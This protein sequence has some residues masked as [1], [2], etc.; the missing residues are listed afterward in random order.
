MVKDIIVN[1]S[2][3]KEGSVVGKYA[4]SVAAALEAHLTGVAFIYDPVVPISGAGYIPAE[5]IEIQRDDNETAAEAA[6]KSFTAATDQAGISAEPLITNASV[7]GAGDHFARMARRFDLAIVGQAE[8]EISS[9]EQIIGETTLFE[10]GRPMIMVPYIQKAPFKTD[11]VMIC[12]DGSRTATRAVADA[13][14]IIRKSGRVEIVIVTNE[15]GKEDE[16]EGAD[17]GQ[18]LARHGLKVDVHRIPGGNIDIAD[19]LLSHAADSS[20]D[21]MVMGGYGHSRLREFVLGGVTRSIFESMTVPVL[22][23]H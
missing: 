12:W 10:S 4:V 13:I 18:H 2:V 15:R 23:S 14:P 22:L 16:I 5:A 21:L 19:A 8:P 11:N 17:I 6:I 7:A 20:A 3:T 1:L 9:M